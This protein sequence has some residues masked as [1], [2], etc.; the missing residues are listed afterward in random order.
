MRR[1]FGPSFGSPAGSLYEAVARASPR[2]MTSGKKQKK[3]PSKRVTRLTPASGTFLGSRDSDPTVV[4]PMTV[5]DLAS[6]TGISA[7]TIRQY[8]TEGVLPPGGRAGE[9]GFDLVHVMCLLAIPQLRA[10]GTTTLEALRARLA[11]MSR[12]DL[13][14]YAGMGAGMDADN[15]PT[16]PGDPPASA[17]AHGSIAHFRR[18]EAIYHEAPVNRVFGARLVVHDGRADVTARARPELHD[19]AGTV[20]RAVL[21]KMLD[22]AASFAVASQLTDALVVTASFHAALFQGIA[23]GPM[24]ASGYVVKASPTLSHAEAILYGP[25]GGELARGAGEYLRGGRGL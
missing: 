10:E 12:E 17:D 7:R 1:R 11:A 24:R 9:R 6:Q 3:K 22:D 15:A 19:A 2:P 14:R 8:L 4:M 25:D 5:A 18:L 20:H 16:S 13:A 23:H 21:I